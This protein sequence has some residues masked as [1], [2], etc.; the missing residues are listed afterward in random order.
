MLTIANAPPPISEIIKDVLY[1]GGVD[2]SQLVE[3]LKA[4]KVTHIVRLSSSDSAKV[5]NE[6]EYLNI[7]LSD[8]PKEDILKHIPVVNQLIGSYPFDVFIP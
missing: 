2:G 5:F 3:E 6:F 1:V 8:E 7:P 4:R